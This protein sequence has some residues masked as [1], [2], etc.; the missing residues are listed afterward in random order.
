MLKELPEEIFGPQI[1]IREYSFFDNPLMPKQVKESWL[2]VQL[3]QERTRGCVALNTTSPL[4]ALRFPRR[5]NEEMFKTVFSSFKDVKIIQ[6]SSMQD[7]FA[8]F[9]DKASLFIVF[10]FSFL[11]WQRCCVAEHTP[12]HIYY[13]MYWD[14]KPGWIPIPP[15]T[16]ED[17]H[18]PP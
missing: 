11:L 17:D 14:E 5:S 7:A 8:G 4:G 6:F 1:G 9:T 2:D 3:C 15:R 16:P 10:G 12:G 18:P 13:D